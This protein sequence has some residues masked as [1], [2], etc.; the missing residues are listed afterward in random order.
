MA[1][2]LDAITAGVTTNP[3]I[4]GS[5]GTLLGNLGTLVRTIASSESAEML[6]NLLQ[7]EGGNLIQHVMANTPSIVATSVHPAPVPSGIPT[8]DK[9]DTTS[10]TGT[11][12]ELDAAQDKIDQQKLRVVETVP[13]ADGTVTVHLRPMPTEAQLAALKAARE[14]TAGGGAVVNNPDGTFAVTGTAEQISGFSAR[15]TDLNETS[16]VTNTDGSHTAQFVKK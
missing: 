10:L 3:T 1:N 5:I 4:Q 8:P 7:R 16:R 13:N 9:L 12:A 14:K 6:A 2:Q 15:N 11:P